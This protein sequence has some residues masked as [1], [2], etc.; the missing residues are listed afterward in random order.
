MLKLGLRPSNKDRGESPVADAMESRSADESIVAA[1]VRKATEIV[2]RF[3]VLAR[4]LRYARCFA[5]LSGL[6]FVQFSV[7][8]SVCTTI[9]TLVNSIIFLRFEKLF[10]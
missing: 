6:G 1:A 9:D 7:R 5:Q 8:Y 10:N 4:F 3:P 2:D